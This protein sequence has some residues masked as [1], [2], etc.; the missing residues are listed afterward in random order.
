MAVLPP[1]AGYM[2]NIVGS[3]AGVVVFGL[4][5]VAA[6]AAGVWF[7]VAGL[8]ALPLLASAE[9]GGPLPARSAF[10]VNGVLLLGAIGLR[11]SSRAGL[12]VAVLQ[13]LRQPAGSRHGHRGE[14]H[15]SPVD[16]ADRAEG[17]LLS[18][19]VLGLRRPFETCSSWA[20]APGT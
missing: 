4:I 20:L 5:V 15:L 13:D 8:A 3:L 2:A 10:L 9:P 18:V 12:V 19:A 11:T 17:I 6:I 1:L 7:G 14:Q 16:G